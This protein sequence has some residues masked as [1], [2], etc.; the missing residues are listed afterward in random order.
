VRNRR[1]RDDGYSLLELVFAA[2]VTMALAAA[3]L[4]VLRLSV[5]RV[6]ALGAARYVGTRLQQARW[7]AVKRSAHVGFRFDP[8]LGNRFA[9]YVDGNGDGLRTADILAGTDAM[10][11]APERLQDHYPGVRFGVLDGVVAV[12]SG[13]TLWSSSDPIRLGSTDILSFGPL[14][15]A[16][17]G[18]LYLHGEDGEQYAVRILGGTGRVRVFRFRLA[19]GEWISP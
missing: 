8:T 18:T 12:E 16:T 3:A 7:E 10:L 1:G 17:S 6:R 13:E 11:G 4:P 2:G 14:G 15:T 9:M 19:T 5:S